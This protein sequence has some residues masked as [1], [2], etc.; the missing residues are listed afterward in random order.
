VRKAETLSLSFADRLE[1]WKL[2]SPE[3]LRPCPGLYRDCFIYIVS[4]EVTN[5]EKYFDF[6][7]IFRLFQNCALFAL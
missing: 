6:L 7:H 5:Y 3:K 1:I 2:Q 4:M